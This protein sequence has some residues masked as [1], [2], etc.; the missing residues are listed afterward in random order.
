MHIALATSSAVPDEFDDDERILAALHHR[1]AHAEF[2]EWDDPAAQWEDFDLVVIRST[3]DYTHRRDEFVAWAD[4]LG[5]RLRNRPAVVRWNSDKRYLAD[6]AEAGIPVVPTRFVEPGEEPGELSGE[7]VVK[8]SISAGGRD[9]GRFRP[10]VHAAAEALI[11]RIGAAGATAM[12][13]PYLETVDREGE[14]ALVFIAGELAHVLAKRA[15]LAP[16]EV[17]PVRDDSLGAAE[18]MYDPTLVTLGEAG[19]DQVELGRRLVAELGRR[20]GSVPLI[21]RVDVVRDEDGAPVLL[22]LEAIEPNLYLHQAPATAELLADA[23]L[24]ELGSD[25]G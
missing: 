11:S 12:V 14:R 22:E 1:G 2:V 25:A 23:I 16:D 10:P 17:A 9:T 24:A 13:Q 6:L 20:F 3:W 19:D 8:P 21:A 7:I 5:E 15:V 4:S 18:A